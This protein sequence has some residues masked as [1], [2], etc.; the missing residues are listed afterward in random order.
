MQNFVSDEVIEIHYENNEN[1]VTPNSKTNVAIA[2]FT[3][4]YAR[5]STF[6]EDEQG[7]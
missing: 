5:W 7:I 6:F 1:L 2:A 4:A 3:T